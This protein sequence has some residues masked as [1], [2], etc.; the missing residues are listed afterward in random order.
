[1]PRA[2]NSKQAEAMAFAE[3]LVSERP[4]WSEF[5]RRMFGLGGFIRMRFPSVE[6]RRRFEMTQ[7]YAELREMLHRLR[8]GSGGSEEEFLR[9]VT[10]RIPNSVHEW[11]K[12]E[13]HEHRVSLN[14]LCVTKLLENYENAK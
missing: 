12:E 10:V 6:E 9:V 8:V 3:T 11:L 5:F 1:M 14:S 7:E 2:T 4:H 13:A